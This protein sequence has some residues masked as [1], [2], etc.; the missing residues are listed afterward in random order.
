[1]AEIEMNK[2]LSSP[3]NVFGH[4]D[5]VLAEQSLSPSQKREILLRWQAEA[6]HM[7]ES[8]AEGFSG[9]ERSLVDDIGRALAR[10]DRENTGGPI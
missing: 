10:L 9:G 1:M 6:I 8:D 4:P 2:A 5:R 3:R 7:Q